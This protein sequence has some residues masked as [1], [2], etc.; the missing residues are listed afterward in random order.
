VVPWSQPE[1]NCMVKSIESS[2]ECVLG[3]SDSLFEPSGFACF[4]T[5]SGFFSSRHTRHLELTLEIGV[6]TRVLART[7]VRSIAHGE[8]IHRRRHRLNNIP[9]VERGTGTI[10]VIQLGDIIR[11]MTEVQDPGRLELHDFDAVA[12]P[13]KLKDNPVRAAV[14]GWILGVRVR[15]ESARCELPPLGTCH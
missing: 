2:Q 13:P 10:I 14:D 6:G 5:Q 11:D 15:E 3:T 12:S 4:E 8:P 1:Q 9:L 7:T